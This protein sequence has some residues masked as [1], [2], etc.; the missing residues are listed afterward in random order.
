MRAQAPRLRADL[1]AHLDYSLIVGVAWTEHHSV[2]A[3]GDR[4]LVAIGRDVADGQ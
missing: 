4:L 3:E 2:L 1:E